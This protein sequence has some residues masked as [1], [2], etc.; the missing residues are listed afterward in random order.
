MAKTSKPKEVFNTSKEWVSGFSHCPELR[1]RCVDDHTQVTHC[2]KT[3]E[4]C[5]YRLCPKV[6]NNQ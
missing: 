5:S 4:K 1:Y 3:G 2:S 6:K